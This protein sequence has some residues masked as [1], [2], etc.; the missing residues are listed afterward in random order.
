VVLPWKFSVAL[1]RDSP[2][3]YFSKSSAARAEFIDLCRETKA[4][5]KRGGAKGF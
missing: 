5:S 1:P 4:P 2:T 3:L